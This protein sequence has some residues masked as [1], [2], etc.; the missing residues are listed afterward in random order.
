MRLSISNIAW[1][2]AEDESIRDL[3]HEF[4]VDAIDIV[5]GKYFLKPETT[6]DKE[7]NKVKNWWSS[8]GIEIIGMQAL[9]FGKTKMNIFGN[10]KS[11]LMMLQYLKA[12]CHIGSLLGANRIT[13]GSPK[14]RDRI[15][16]N[17][18]ETKKIAK[19]FFRRLGGIAEKAGV[20]ICLEPCPALYGGNFMKTSFETAK[21]VAAIRHPA[22]RMQLDSGAISINKEDP[23]EILLKYAEYIG[24][25]HVSEPN[26]VPL[27]DGTVDHKNFFKALTKH[28]PNSLLSIEM[29][30][31]QNESHLTS[32]RRA[33]LIANEIY[34]SKS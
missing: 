24:H 28:L 3:L 5:P 21:M 11:R 31:T 22:I 1:D 16:L 19:D 29:V 17:D 33:L 30:A 4:H 20:I 2:V 25:V 12:V 8:N 23:F 34:K 10:D 6:T 13:F 14:N 15:G 26:L 32:I 18:L 9:L 27:G 7:I